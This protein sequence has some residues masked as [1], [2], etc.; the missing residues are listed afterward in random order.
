MMRLQMGE[1]P[2]EVRRPHRWSLTARDL[3]AANNDVAY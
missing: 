1:L 3:D 2:L